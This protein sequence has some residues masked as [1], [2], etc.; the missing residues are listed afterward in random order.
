MSGVLS[1]S[2]WSPGVFQRLGLHLRAQTSSRCT[3]SILGEVSALNFCSRQLL[4]LLLLSVVTFGC[5][6]ESADL[7]ALASDSKACQT[8]SFC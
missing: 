7:L 5:L 1:H 3:I 4:I 6:S 2:V 8:R